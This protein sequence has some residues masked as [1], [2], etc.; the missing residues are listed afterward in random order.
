[1]DERRKQLGRGLAFPLRVDGG[2]RLVVTDGQAKVEESIRVILGTGLGERVMRS[3]FGSEVPSL[4]FELCTPATEARLAAAIRAALARW[5]ARID[6]LDVKVTRDAAVETRLVASLSYRLR[7]TNAVLN[8][9]YPFYQDE[10]VE[11][12]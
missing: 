2:G 7:A 1:M 12:R 11:E 9:V 6:V 5:E 3:G 10:G 4:L 8:Q